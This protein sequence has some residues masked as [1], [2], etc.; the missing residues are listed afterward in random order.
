MC[1]PDTA[2]ICVPQNEH[3]HRHTGGG[4][5]IYP[6]SKRGKGDSLEEEEIWAEVF[7]LCF[8]GSMP[9]SPECAMLKSRPPEAMVLEG[10][11][12]C[13]GAAWL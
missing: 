4:T 7:G 13:L 1:T 2:L 11:R 6:E 5:G 12:E 8:L 10:R 3:L 9:V